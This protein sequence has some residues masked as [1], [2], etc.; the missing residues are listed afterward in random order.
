MKTV[1]KIALGAL[2]M[3]AVVITACEMSSSVN[4]ENGK[5]ANSE[6][7]YQ[8]DISDVY[9]IAKAYINNKRIAA[10]PD[11]AMPMQRLSRVKLEQG[12]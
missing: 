3:S 8:T 9:G 4:N 12:S 1:K 10:K 2:L 11:Q 7:R 5:F 6:K